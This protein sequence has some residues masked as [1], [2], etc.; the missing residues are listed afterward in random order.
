MMIKKLRMVNLL[1]LLKP[2]EQQKLQYRQILEDL[3]EWIKFNSL[4][5]SHTE[6]D[7]LITKCKDFCI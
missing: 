4:L 3:L 5:N 1:S 2:V 6:I 7:C